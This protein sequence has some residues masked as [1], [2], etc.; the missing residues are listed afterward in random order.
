V[1]AVAIATFVSLALPSRASA[2][3][4][5]Q[6]L[7]PDAGRPYA[8]FVTLDL[9]GGVAR[10]TEHSRWLLLGAASAGLGLYNGLRIWTFGAGI[11]G[12]R[13]D[14]RAAIVTISRTGVESGLG[15]RWGGLW[16]LDRAAP[17]LSA[18]VSLS[19]LNLQ[20]DILFDGARTC[21][22]SLFVR[23]PVGFLA[24]LGLGGRR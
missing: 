11:R 3:A 2:Q 10:S 7:A 5:V 4:M 14:E 8:K 22:L 16:D 15:L 18:G 13:N 21:H 20:G 23:I 24:Y 1:P 12:M 19:V 6:A 9:D 17:G